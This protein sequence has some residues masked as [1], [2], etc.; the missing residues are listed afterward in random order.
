MGK[1]VKAAGKR[2]DGGLRGGVRPLPVRSSV[3]LRRPVDIWHKPAL[4]AVVA[5]AIPDAALFA[6]GRMDLVLYTSAGAMCVLYG[7]GLPYAAR[8][9]TLPWVVLGMVASLGLALTAASLVSSAVV[10][11]ALASVVAAVHKVVCEAT[12]IG[13]PGNLIFTFIAASAFFVPQRIGEVPAH[14]ALA[15]AG[16]AVAWLVGMA[17]AVVRPRGPERI[18]TARAL[19]AASAQL[20]TEATAHGAAAEAAVARARQATAGAVNAAWHTVF[21][22][23]AR[24]PAKAEARAGL[25]RLLIRAEAALDGAM[26][27]EHGGNG[28]GSFDDGT[29]PPPSGPSSPASAEP[30]S[31]PVAVLLAEAE[32]FGWWAR[33]VRGG[34][35][36]PAATLTP[37]QRAE[38]DGVEWEHRHIDRARESG[39]PPRHGE[40]ARGDLSRGAEHGVHGGERQLRHEE[41]SQAAPLTGA[42]GRAGEAP[43]GD[44]GAGLPTAWGASGAGFSG[45]GPR[46]PA[47]GRVRGWRAVGAAFRSGSPLLPVG[48]RTAVGCALAG[49]VSMGLGVGHPYWSVVTAASVFQANTTL[50]WQRALQRSVG[51]LLGL[52]VFTALLPVIHT[53]HLAMIAL[54]L[55]FQFGAEAWITRNYW[56][57]SVCV[58]PMALLLTEFGNPLP[59]RVLVAD[60]WIDTVVGAVLGLVC[61]VL[62]TNRRAGDRIGTALERTAAAQIAAGRLLAADAAPGA[63]HARET[64]QAR[65]RLA[66]ALAE[67]REAVD[68]ASGEWWQRALPE[69]RVA[70]AERHGHRT[71]ALLARRP[72]GAAPSVRPVPEQVAAAGT[73]DGVRR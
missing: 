46:H 49:W 11:V 18:A 32:M 50:S 13:P 35:E 25:E 51:N 69:E 24:T 3:R 52:V 62:V 66:G 71:L 41:Q 26:G 38:L 48:L 40:R 28:A 23:P 4:S 53:G 56:L 7:H 17:P 31:A 63:A 29:P 72:A 47:P 33:A 73:I 14:L 27:G 22:V 12:R 20:R 30:A 19:E 2:G 44:D 34:G 39:Q 58:T 6:G 42:G 64:G 37:S 54:A 61:C 15:L 1:H 10:L 57:G 5:L 43:D 9:R 68:V 55:V 60:R 36:L 45:H 70:R 59:A 8:A 65:D 21:L 16:G 67:L